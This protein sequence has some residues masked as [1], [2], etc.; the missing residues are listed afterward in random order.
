[1]VYAL[2]RRKLCSKVHDTMPVSVNAFIDCRLIWHWY[3]KHSEENGLTLCLAE[4]L[5]L[6]LVFY[7]YYL[8]SINNPSKIGR[9]PLSG[10]QS[11]FVYPIFLLRTRLL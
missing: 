6:H 4:Y 3:D 2:L 10:E 9:I 7:D 5:L 8:D 11:S 1:M